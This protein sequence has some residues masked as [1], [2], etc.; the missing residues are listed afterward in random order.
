[1]LY[2]NLLRTCFLVM[3]HCIIGQIHRSTGPRSVHTV[4]QPLNLNGKNNSFSLFHNVFVPNTSRLPCRL[5][6]FKYRVPLVRKSV[7]KLFVITLPILL[8]FNYRF[9]NFHTQYLFAS[10]FSSRLRSNSAVCIRFTR[11][12][13]T[14]IE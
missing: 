12:D 10:I 8:T 11:L 6:A 1:M 13:S 3:N 7:S 4:Q 2:V 5:S 14:Y 9:S